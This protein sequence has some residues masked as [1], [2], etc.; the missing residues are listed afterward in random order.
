MSHNNDLI[1]D[2]SLQED[3]A[4]GKG[5]LQYHTSVSIFPNVAILGSKMQIIMKFEFYLPTN[6]NQCLNS[7]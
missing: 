2:C 6:N 1:S 3:D 5:N 4:M 7:F